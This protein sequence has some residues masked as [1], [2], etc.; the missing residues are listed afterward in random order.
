MPNIIMCEKLTTITQQV[1][2]YVKCILLLVA[3]HC[4]SL[5]EIYIHTITKDNKEW[6]G[7]LLHMTCI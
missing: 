2:S 3:N 5:S 6:P 1:H 4:T 7:L